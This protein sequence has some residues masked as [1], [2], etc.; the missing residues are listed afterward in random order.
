MGGFDHAPQTVEKL[1]PATA[2]R[3]ARVGLILFVVYLI[4]YASFVVISAM[5]PELMDTVLSGINLAVWY[6]LALIAAAIVM[7]FLYLWL[8]RFPVAGPAGHS[9]SN[10]EGRS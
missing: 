1:D 2:D 10:V 6:G 4:F 8:C 3:N 5:K 7:A 9:S